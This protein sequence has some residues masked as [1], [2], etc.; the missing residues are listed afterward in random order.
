[1]LLF[2]I[3]MSSINYKIVS[4]KILTIETTTR[5]CSVCLSKDGLPWIV[6]ETRSQSGHAEKLTLFIEEVLETASLTLQDVDAIAV[7]QG[8]GSYTGLRI[9]VSTVKGLCYALDK[10]MLA[11]DTLQALAWGAKFEQKR[12]KVAYVSLM[13]ARRMDAYVGIYDE[14]I[15]V[16]KAPYFCTL[17]PTSFDFLLE[18]KGI[19]QIVLVGDGISKYQEIATNSN[20]IASTVDLPSAKYLGALAQ[21]AY[22]QQQFVDVAYFEPF[23]LKK[24]NITK[25]KPKF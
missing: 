13:D 9:G 2:T 1:M 4:T 7:S 18:E 23:Y 10:P 20:I 25:P 19:E 8:P 12:T 3:C 22:N 15:S 21:E 14:N 17:T 5:S 11:V 24:P 16:L 6:K